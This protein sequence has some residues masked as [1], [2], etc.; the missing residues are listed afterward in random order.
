MRK[1]LQL[2][3]QWAQLAGASAIGQ[4]AMPPNI[5]QGDRRKQDAGELQVSLASR[6]GVG[7]RRRPAS[8]ILAAVAGRI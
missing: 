4:I 6:S 5:K 2:R 1:V 8:A 7:Q 3:N